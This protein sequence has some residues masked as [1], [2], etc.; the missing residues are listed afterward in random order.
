MTADSPA[1]TAV[2]D[3]EMIRAMTT[4]A[5]IYTLTRP[6]AVIAYAALIAAFVVNAI[7]LG[8]VGGDQEQTTTL[9]WTML[10]IAALI[11]ASILFTRA[12]TR[13]AIS[14]TMPPGSVV[15]VEVG[16]ESLKAVSKAGASEIRY[17]TFRSVHVGRHA[18]LLRLRGTSVVTVL[19]RAV[20]SDEDVALLKSRI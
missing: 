16:E 14:T 20:L 13:R 7:V 3:A 8:M 11:V 9:T 4:D 1:R 17:A 15:R 18:A 2:V 10:A 6:L 12:S 19:P 5:V